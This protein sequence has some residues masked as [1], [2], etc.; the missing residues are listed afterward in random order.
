[1]AAEEKM[2]AEGAAKKVAENGAAAEIIA[3]ANQRYRERR[4]GEMRYWRSCRESEG[5]FFMII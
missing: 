1:M 4:E 2:V 5:F 3:K